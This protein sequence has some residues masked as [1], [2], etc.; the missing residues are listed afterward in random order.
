MKGSWI[1][2]TKASP[3]VICGRDHWCSRT[4]DGIVAQCRHSDH[5]PTYGRGLEKAGKSGVYWHFIT[6][7]RPPRGAPPSRSHTE[8]AK[9]RATP[10][11]LHIVYSAFLEL[12]GHTTNEINELTRRGV[13]RGSPL[14]KRCR[15]LPLPGRAKLAASLVARGLEPIMARTPGF[16]VREGKQGPYW[17]IA[18]PP[19][20]IV[21]VHDA[22]GRIVSLLL[23]PE[24]PVGIN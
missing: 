13:P 21:P 17:T 24:T 10:D 2:A 22:A 23:R 1:E 12:L 18:G 20:L 5:H 11:E 4:K 9:R 7:E 19:G 8:G 16:F 3:C 14:V 15:W 6:G